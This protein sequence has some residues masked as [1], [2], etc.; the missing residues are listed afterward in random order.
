MHQLNHKHDRDNGMARQ[1][2]NE[3]TPELL[4]KLNQ[5]SFTAEELAE[6]DD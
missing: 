6:M 5:S 1:Y 4:A 3:L 2:D